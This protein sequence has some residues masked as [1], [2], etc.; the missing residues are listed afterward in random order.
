MLYYKNDETRDRVFPKGGAQQIIQLP[1]FGDVHPG[2]SELLLLKNIA[3]PQKELKL[4][5]DTSF[6][7]FYVNR[8]Y[9]LDELE[10]TSREVRQHHFFLISHRHP[11]LYIFPIS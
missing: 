1:R 4:W 6:M 8:V 5:F 2:R 9:F 7:R 11:Q 3:V 10:A